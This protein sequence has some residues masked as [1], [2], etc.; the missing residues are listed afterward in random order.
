MPTRME[1]DPTKHKRFP[2]MGRCIYCGRTDDLSEEHIVPFALN[3]AW[4]LP[5]SSCPTCSKIT[6]AM[7]RDAIQ[8]SFTAY[9]VQQGF[10]TRR[11]KERKKLKVQV[12]KQEGGVSH[13]YYGDYKEMPLFLLHMRLQRPGILIGRDKAFDRHTAMSL[14]LN[15]TM[16]RDREILQVND[17]NIIQ[18]YDH[19]A[20]ARMIAKAAHAFACGVLGPDAF[21]HLLPGLILG[22]VKWLYNYLVGGDFVPDAPVFFLPRL[23]QQHEMRLTS[24]T[25]MG[26]QPFYVVKLRLF[27]DMESTV[28]TIV[29]GQ[30]QVALMQYRG[31]DD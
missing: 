9:R 14:Q 22:K 4:V 21:T 24:E 29:V 12:T 26:G 11:P 19:E 30:P 28:Y 1:T 6:S 5:D 7:E 13:S 23:Q 8:R 3:G 31:G 20:V 25:G 17:L 2:S 18:P 15:T 10:K 16:K 27:A